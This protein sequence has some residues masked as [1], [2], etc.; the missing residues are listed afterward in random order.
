MSSFSSHRPYAFYLLQCK[1]KND[2]T[3]VTLMLLQN[4]ELH[5]GK[6]EILKE[7]PLRVLCD[8]ALWTLCDGAKI[9]QLLE[10]LAYLY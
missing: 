3:S 5:Y 4:S 6:V 9:F 1:Y 7:H 10:K 2:A 8:H